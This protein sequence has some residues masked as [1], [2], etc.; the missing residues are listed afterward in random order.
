MRLSSKSGLRGDIAKQLLP[1]RSKPGRWE[2]EPWRRP[3][4][5]S[6]PGGRGGRTDRPPPAAGGPAGPPCPCRRPRAVTCRGCSSRSGSGTSRIHWG[7]RGC[8]LSLLLFAYVKMT[9]PWDTRKNY[10][11]EM[12]MNCM[13]C[14]EIMKMK[15]SWIAWFEIKLGRWNPRELHD[16]RRN[17]GGE[18]VVDCMISE[19]IMDIKWSWIAWFETFWGSA[20]HV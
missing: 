9:K 13:I 8:R 20:R 15:W 11:D 19:K 6:R 5:R 2:G 17:Y 1:C 7:Q 12:V 18:M 10:G 14:D 4:G 3:G 16:L